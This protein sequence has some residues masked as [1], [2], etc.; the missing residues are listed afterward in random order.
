MSLLKD[1][2]MKI[3]NLVRSEKIKYDSLLA[4]AQAANVLKTKKYKEFT[5][6]FKDV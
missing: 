5:N 2:K 4:A 1:K 6:M 3:S